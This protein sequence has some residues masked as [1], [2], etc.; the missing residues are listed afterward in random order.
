[1]GRDDK[2]KV[3]ISIRPHWVT[4]IFSGRK[5]IEIRK[6][7]PKI[8][9]AF[10]AAVYVTK[11][12]MSYIGKYIDGQDD[13]FGHVYHG[14]TKIL[15]APKYPGEWTA[16]AAGKIV[17]KILVDRCWEYFAEIPQDY[18]TLAYFGCA[19]LDDVVKY[20][21]GRDRLYGWNILKSVKYDTPKKLDEFG[22]KRPPQSWQYLM[23]G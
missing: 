16:G 20:A 4:E 6:T 13:G 19:E 12:E 1:M 15:K 14:K 9:G 3:L 11:P 18:P 8:Q 17:G 7:A 23:E 21:G 22:L 2:P 10:W 5:T